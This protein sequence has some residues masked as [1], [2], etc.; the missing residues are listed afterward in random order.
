[1]LT[2]SGSDLRFENDQWTLRVRVGSVLD[3]HSLVHRPTGRV[4]CDES[5]CY[6]FVAAATDGSGYAGPPAYRSTDGSTG[7]PAAVLTNRPE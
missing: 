1:M 3:P 2:E 4:V 7:Q 5:Y 6:H